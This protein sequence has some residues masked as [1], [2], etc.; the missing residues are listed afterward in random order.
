MYL[1]GL[2]L[3]GFKSFPRQTQLVFEP[4]VGVIIGPNGSGK[5]NLADAVMWALGE[6][7]P[8]NLR[9]ASMQDVIFAGSDGRRPLAH[10]EVELT[11]DNHDGALPLPT[12]EVSVMRRV[13]RD[14]SSQYFINH[15]GCRLTDVIELMAPV[16]LGRELHSI[17]GQG[18]VEAFLAGKPDDR[19]G[20]IEEAA[21]LGAYK[22]RRDR[23]ELKLRDVRRNLKQAALLEREVATQLAPLRRQANAAEQLHSLEVELAET[24]A[25][26][27]TGSLA[28]V[29]AELKARRELTTVEVD[30]ARADAGLENVAEARSAE[31]DAFA[32]RVAEHERRTQRLLRARLL[33]AGR[34]STSTSASQSNVCALSRRLSAPPA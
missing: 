6:Q 12:D 16:G 9:G 13:S 28:S 15:S 17:I 14:G 29:D 21:G 19:R 23:A 7:S 24:R 18:R 4:G 11:F 33:D 31:E 30:R 1:K 27:L 32:Q 2:R 20:R 34:A 25:R 3:K 26:L 8:S 5:S 10:A 22:R